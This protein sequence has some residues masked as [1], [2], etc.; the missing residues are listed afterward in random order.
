M[1]PVLIARDPILAPIRDQPRF[2]AAM[3]RMWE[4]QRAQRQRVETRR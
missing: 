3:D 1:D 2:Q 4:R